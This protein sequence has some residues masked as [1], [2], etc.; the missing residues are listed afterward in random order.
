MFGVPAEII[1]EQ[2]NKYKI[3]EGFASCKKYFTMFVFLP[4]S[5]E[6]GT[7]NPTDH[8]CSKNDLNQPTIQQV[9]LTFLLFKLTDT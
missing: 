6:T 7:K 8:R 9:C 5:K 3:I 2:N 4:G 1:N